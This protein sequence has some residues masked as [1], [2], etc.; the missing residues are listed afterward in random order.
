MGNEDRGKGSAKRRPK[1]APEVNVTNR[2][3][4]LFEMAKTLKGLMESECEEDGGDIEFVV[5]S[6]PQKQFAAPP[7]VPRAQV[8]QRVGQQQQQ[9]QQHQPQHFNVYAP[10]ST[11]D[12]S[13]QL[14]IQHGVDQT[15]IERP[16]SGRMERN[17]GHISG[18]TCF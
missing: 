4:T 12:P 3:K 18:P 6:L 1:G 5:K 14:G 17:T 9:Q 16:A 10:A 11:R 8:H 13:I 2:A 7:H 15:P